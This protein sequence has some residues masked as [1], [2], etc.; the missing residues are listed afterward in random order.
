M[1]WIKECISLSCHF[2]YAAAGRKK[3]VGGESLCNDKHEFLFYYIT[4][5]ILQQDSLLLILAAACRR[6]HLPGHIIQ[7]RK[8]HCQ[9]RQ[10]HKSVLGCGCEIQ[11]APDE[12]RHLK[13]CLSRSHSSSGYPR[14]FL[15]CIHFCFWCGC[16]KLSLYCK[17]TGWQSICSSVMNYA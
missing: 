14:S 3:N 17:N 8:Y 2:S 5:S 13:A 4:W 16:S 11:R 6:T 15:H 10:L 1:W 12:V 9:R 7:I